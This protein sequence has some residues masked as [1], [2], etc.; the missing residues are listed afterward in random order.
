VRLLR[1]IL[2]NP[3]PPA[4]K[5]TTRPIGR[6]A[7]QNAGLQKRI[8]DLLAKGA[9]DIRVDQEQLALTGPGRTLQRVGRN[10]PDLQ[11]TLNGQRYY[12]EF[13]APGSLRGPGHEYRIKANDPRA[14]VKIW[15]CPPT[16]P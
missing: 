2:V 3:K 10:R 15:Y 1:D 4:L 12:E 13:E 7:V 9:T 5:A 11:Y 14:V 8:R 6:N 16:C